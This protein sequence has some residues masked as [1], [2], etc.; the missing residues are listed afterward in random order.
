MRATWKMGDYMIHDINAKSDT[1]YHAN[2]L[3]P[4]ILIIDW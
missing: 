3:P 2:L 1:K 4:K